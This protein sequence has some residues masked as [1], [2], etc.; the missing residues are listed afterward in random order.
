MQISRKFPNTIRLAAATLFFLLILPSLAGCGGKPDGV[1]TS[2]P[3]TGEYE[4][5]V[6]PAD[7]PAAGT[8]T[9]LT[10][11][12]NP[13]PT[14]DPLH[15][16]TTSARSG[17]QI[18]PTPG[19]A[20]TPTLSGKE[21]AEKA[22]QAA[23]QGAS[24]EAEPSPTNVPLPTETPASTSVPGPTERSAVSQTP[25]PEL[26]S[27]EQMVTSQ[28]SEILPWFSDPPDRVHSDLAGFIVRRQWVSDGISEQEAEAIALLG[29][30][31]A[32]EAELALYLSQVSWMGDSVNDSE[33]AWLAW[34][35]KNE[36]EWREISPLIATGSVDAGLVHRA[37]QLPWV[38]DGITDFEYETIDELQR[39]IRVD[40]VLADRVLAFP[41]LA[42]E[43]GPGYTRALNELGT[44]SKRYGEL[45]VQIAGEPWLAEVQYLTARHYRP[46]E[47]L[48]IIASHDKRLAEQLVGLLT[49]EF[50]RRDQ[51]LL[52]S[53]R[54]LQQEGPEHFQQLVREPWVTDG[55]DDEEMA[56]LITTPDIAKHSPTDL[57]EMLKVR[58]VT[59]AT[60]NLPLSGRVTFWA[61]QKVP[62]APDDDILA[63]AE[64]ALRLLEELTGVPLPTSHIV[65]LVAVTEEYSDFERFDSNLVQPWPKGAHAGQYFRLGRN[66]A[67]QI[68][69]H[70]LYHELAHYY[71][72][73]VPAWFM[74]GGAEFAVDYIQYRSG[75]FSLDDWKSSMQLAGEVTCHNGA[76]NLHDL[77]YPGIFYL[78][79]F[80]KGCFY[81]MGRHFLSSL[82]HAFGE[83]ITRRAMNEIF[84]LMRTFENRPFETR[85]V[86]GKDV[87]LA[88]RNHLRADQVEELN[89]LFHR[90]HGGP[91]TDIGNPG[92][93]DHGDGPETASPL[94]P[95]A[96]VRG[97][98]E[99]GMDTDYFRVDVADG[100]RF[101]VVIEHDLAT[102]TYV[103]GDLYVRIHPPAE[104]PPERLARSQGAPG[105]LDAKWQP[106]GAGPYYLSVEST[107]GL[108]GSYDIRLSEGTQIGDD[109]GSGPLQATGVQIG[110]PISGTID[111]DRDVNYFRVQA[112]SGRGYR[113]AVDSI[114]LG[115]TRA[116]AFE[117]DGTTEVPEPRGFQSIIGS[118]VRWRA[119]RTGD[120]IVAV[121]T[122]AT[123]I[124]SYSL[125]VSE[126][127][128]GED[129]H[130][131]Q[132]ATA[133]AVSLNT[134]IPAVLEDPFDQD[135]FRFRA[136]G[137]RTYHIKVDHGSVPA[138]PVILYS[139][140]GATVLKRHG[141]TGGHARGTHFPWIA[142]QS[143]DYFVRIHSPNGQTGD[144]RVTVVLGVP[145]QD[146]HGDVPG[147][148]TQID[149]GQRVSGV[150]EHPNDFD[151]FRFQAQAGL[152]YEISTRFEGESD[153]R[154][155]LYGPDGVA[156]VARY[157]DFGQRQSG[158]YF[159]WDATEPG[160]YFAVMF[161]PKGDM[162]PYS[163][164]LAQLPQG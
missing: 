90:L 46:L 38:M 5:S 84:H 141:R 31:A 57:Y 164:E 50:S 133:T 48:N 69:L 3:F 65:A 102:D 82:F 1:E 53:L 132:P 13:P 20:T 28:L 52:T 121:D 153:R 127:A 154:V 15:I 139:S 159:V 24:L 106:A 124:G 29:D 35:T 135:Y 144:Y 128:P 95:G 17:P 75:S 146:D 85:P 34:F 71:F 122:P 143:G 14:P 66:L 44:L 155:L 16:A 64:N 94:T 120:Y 18:T 26:L 113:A 22:L 36:V 108:T 88:F 61:V 136:D 77:G 60:F 19:E 59:S 81:T 109:H 47:Q 162:G 125:T 148:A 138:Q 70:V 140:D 150:L 76:Q 73:F 130:G 107:T 32:R 115:F 112:V 126:F 98:L 27:P 74:E 68:S 30:I 23:I 43:G 134:V 100:Q 10:P 39:I 119:S 80:H 40:T 45:A 104:G 8:I 6:I 160:E 149:V 42:R 86:T 37:M 145:G 2:I 41:W 156:D 63:Q 93:D 142:P 87:Y 129:D 116:T 58:H 99:H 51:D 137:G 83:E 11:A 163:V 62:F 147:F 67:G 12:P 152:R 89:R 101:R 54:Y 161:S 4:A 96:M 111:D 79:S 103:G 9:L 157:S 92:R 25:T 118:E 72:D 158:K 110:Q 56:F 151:Y 105:G 55:L 33:L 49:G 117:A 114:S 97:K 123:N 78:G 7:T 21:L 131:D 91:L